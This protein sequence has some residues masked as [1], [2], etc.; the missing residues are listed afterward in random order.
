ML[1][2]GDFARRHGFKMHHGN[3]YRRHFEVANGSYIRTDGMVLGAELEFDAPPM[4]SPREL[5][6]EQ[7]SKYDRT[8]SELLDKGGGAASSRTKSTFTCDL[9]VV[10]NL[11][12]DII[13]SSN[14]IFDNHVLSR[15][16]HLFSSKQPL[17]HRTSH[18]ATPSSCGSKMNFS[19]CLLF[20]RI[21]SNKAS[22]NKKWSWLSWG[23]RGPP[24]TPPPPNGIPLQNG[25]TWEELLEAE[26]ARR[27]QMQLRIGSLPESSNYKADMQQAEVQRQAAWDT[28]HPR[29]PPPV[30][31]GTRFGSSSSLLASGATVPLPA[32][33]VL[34]PGQNSAGG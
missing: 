33:L 7:Y 26:E 22:K 29:P 20:M 25:P 28:D 4:T 19:D 2:S 24:P 13:L 5:D 15:F 10:E 27:N 6:W 3:K 1:V 17:A 11:P 21:R 12:C 34:G 18:H 8:L 14:F 32:V 23:W 9:Y 31:R 16:E 30:P